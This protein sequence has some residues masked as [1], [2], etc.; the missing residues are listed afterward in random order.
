MARLRQETPTSSNG[1]L[2]QAVVVLDSRYM[3][4][5][6]ANCYIIVVLGTFVAVYRQSGRNDSLQGARRQMGEANAS[7]SLIG[8]AAPEVYGLF[9]YPG[10]YRRAAS[11][12]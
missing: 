11:P 5:D 4:G 12:C 10:G 6:I 7:L 9:G 8:T 3:A 2:F 1:P